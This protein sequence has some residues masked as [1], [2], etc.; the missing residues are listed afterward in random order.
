VKVRAKPRVVVT[1]NRDFEGAEEDPE[2]RARE[3]IRGTAEDVATALEAGGYDVAC[4]GVTDDL[5]AT[6]QALRMRSPAVVFNLCESIRGDNRFE[7]LLPFL[8]EL[9]NIR[10][11]G[12]PP[13]ALSLALHKD[14]AK[15]LLRARGVSVPSGGACTTLAEVA[16]LGSLRFPLFVKPAREDASVGITPASVV[17]DATALRRQVKHVLDRYKQ[18]AIV[19]E[20][21]EG[22][23]IYVSMLGRQGD[24]PEVLPLHE[25][26]FSEMPADRPRIVSFEGKW[27][28]D[29][30]DFRGTK[31]IRCEG[32]PSELIVRLGKTAL[33]A[34]DAIGIRDYG[35]VDVRLAAD[36]TPF[37]IDVNPN[38][39]LSTGAGFARAAAAGGL[40]YGDVVRRIVALALSRRAE[41]EKMDD[42]S[43]R[44]ARPT[45]L[46]AAVG[47]RG[48]QP[49]PT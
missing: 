44:S 31:P 28:E 13:L 37:V 15:E 46:A 19:E 21:I 25:I 3:D 43:T 18:P 6:V 26:D 16:R 17:R 24:T 47:A 9:E 23:E 49:L 2:N 11:T 20:Y 4:L 7:A 1:F 38:C 30:V 48:R 39:D 32:L 27:V 34:A 33:A 35:R 29:S 36:G 10:Y 42:K 40:G 22:R 14:R 41:P 12:S 45:R 5:V 8:L